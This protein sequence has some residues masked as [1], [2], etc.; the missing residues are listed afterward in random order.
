MITDNGKNSNRSV[1]GGVGPPFFVCR[2][3][4]LAD[5]GGDLGPREFVAVHGDYVVD[6]EV[7]A[8]DG[9]DEF[10]EV[11]VH[12]EVADRAFFERGRCGGGGARGR[13]PSSFARRLGICRYES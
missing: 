3:V 4:V 12:E 1:N 13:R 2:S 8:G 6:G 11:L 10:G 9:L 5:G 7:F